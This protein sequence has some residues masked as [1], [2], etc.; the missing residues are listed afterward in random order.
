MKIAVLSSHTPSLFWFRMDMMQSFIEK[1]HQVIAVGNEDESIWKEKF[2][3]NGIEYIKADIS[4]NGMNP[5]A[6][7]KTFA[8][9][10]KI[11]KKHKPDKIFTYQAKT[12]IYGSIAARLLKI[13]S[14]FPLIA[15]LG[16]VFLG[17]S[18]KAKIISCILK[19]EY[20]VALSSAEKVFF[21][22]TRRKEMVDATAK[23]HLR[24]FSQTGIAAF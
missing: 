13:R 15:G 17:E 19:L 9:L 21:E 24:L 4:R 16:S 18:L 22:K 2:L 23:S 10:Y 3:K 20:K 1:G 11:I 6:D 14:V 12:V 5:F 8:C 7:I